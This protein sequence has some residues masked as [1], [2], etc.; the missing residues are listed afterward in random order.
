[1]LSL[2][3]ALDLKIYD[4][5]MFWAAC[6]LAYFGFLRSAEFTVPNL[7]SFNSSMHLQVADLAFDSLTAPTS[8]RV[9][10]KA[11]KTD[12]FRKGCQIHIGRGHPPLCAVSAMAAY[13][14][15][16][17]GASGPLFLLKDGRPLSRDI[18]STWL[19]SIFSG[20]GVVGNYSSHSFRIGAATVAARN[21][22]PDH[23]IQALGRWSSNAYMT[24]IRTP[25]DALAAFSRHLS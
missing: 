4:H 18:L 10:I 11:S 24:Y 23:L 25:A 13:L 15:L 5:S 1:M 2:F 8:L 20:A 16:R 21:G 12:P 9:I 14:Q 7:A 17:G 22:I 6:T 3:A 19:R